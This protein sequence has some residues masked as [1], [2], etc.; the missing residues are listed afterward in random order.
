MSKG[1]LNSSS[2]SKKK[3]ILDYYYFG[4]REVDQEFID[5][6]IKEPNLPNNVKRQEVAI[7]HITHYTLKVM[8]L[9]LKTQ[10]NAKEGFL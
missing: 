8:T 7:L 1:F 9:L 10:C 5:L 2:E 3:S 4:K 6:F